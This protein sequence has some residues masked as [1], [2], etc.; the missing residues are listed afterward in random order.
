MSVRNY[1]IGDQ[2]ERHRHYLDV[3]ASKPRCGLSAAVAKWEEVPPPTSDSDELLTNKYGDSD[4]AL[5]YRVCS[6]YFL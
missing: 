3:F 5:D 4:H 6:K 2:G 1:V